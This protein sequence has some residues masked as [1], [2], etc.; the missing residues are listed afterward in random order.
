MKW[1]KGR[2]VAFDERAIRETPPSVAEFISRMLIKSAAERPSMAEVATELVLLGEDPGWHGAGAA[3]QRRTA[4][5]FRL[6]IDD[7]GQLLN[8][9]GR[10]GLVRKTVR[11]WRDYLRRDFHPSQQ[12]SD[13]SSHWLRTHS[14]VFTPVGAS[15]KAPA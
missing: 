4:L 11:P 6:D 7:S 12:E 3:G 9:F 15:A 13:Q 8:R 14:D 2:G 10:E 5:N 1:L